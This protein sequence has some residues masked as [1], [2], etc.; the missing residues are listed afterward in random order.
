MFRIQRTIFLG[1]LKK[2]LEKILTSINLVYVEA[3]HR[4]QA[5]VNLYPNNPKNAI[6]F[7]EK[8]FN[9]MLQISG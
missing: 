2:I 8:W 9:I 5:K 7:V 4:H 6:L 1:L 3:V